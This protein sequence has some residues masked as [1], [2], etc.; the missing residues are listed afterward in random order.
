MAYRFLDN[1]LEVQIRRLFDEMATGCTRRRAD[2]EF[3]ADYD[4]Q[5]IA[6]NAAR[7]R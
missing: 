3:S 4:D 6:T 7:S 5:S 2:L 1:P